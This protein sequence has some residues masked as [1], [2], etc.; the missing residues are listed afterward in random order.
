MLPGGQGSGRSL[1][2]AEHGIAGDA[3]QG[4]LESLRLHVDGQGEETQAG[5]EFLT[6]PRLQY[7]F[8]LVVI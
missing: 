4:R 3:D 6:G 8:N 1:R 2:S 7:I 5:S